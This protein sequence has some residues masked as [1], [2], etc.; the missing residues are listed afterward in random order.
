[1]NV[2]LHEPL[3]LSI[4]EFV[5]SLS[6]ELGEALHVVAPM[7]GAGFGDALDRITCWEKFLTSINSS[8]PLRQAYEKPL[9]MHRD[10]SNRIRRTRPLFTLNTRQH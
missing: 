6:D 8:L 9:L 10:I 1:M 5:D 3:E 7:D 4:Q 2:F